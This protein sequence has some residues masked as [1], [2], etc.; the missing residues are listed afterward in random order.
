M[1]TPYITTGQTGPRK[2]WNPALTQREAL[3]VGF[4]KSE[5]DSATL[6]ARMTVDA[7]KELGT[8]RD[9][10]E[11]TLDVGDLLSAPYIGNG[12][13]ELAGR[14]ESEADPRIDESQGLVENVKE[15]LDKIMEDARPIAA[16]EFGATYSV[17]GAVDRVQDHNKTIEEDEGAGK[18]HHRRVPRLMRRLATWAPWI[19]AAGFFTFISYYLNV[20]LLEPWQDWFGW[21]FG[22]SVVVVIIIGQTILVRHAA[23]D[24]NHAREANANGNRHPAEASRIQ[25]NRY[26]ALTAVTAVAVTSGMIWRG[27]AALGDASFGVTA[28]M[29]FVAAVTGLLLP[30]LSYLGMALDGSRV[31]RERDSLVAQLDKDLEWHQATISNGRRDLA[32]AAAIADTLKGRTFLDICSTTQEAVDEVYEF[33]AKIRLLIGGLSADPP[34]RTTRTIHYDANN[35]ITGGYIG[36]SIPGAHTVNLGPLFD[37]ARHLSELERQAA[38]LMV[39]ID[40]AS[41]H[42]W[43]EPR[44]T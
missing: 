39:L 35:N 29:V 24:H 20:P 6:Y 2:H 43:G 38:A 30:T 40:A 10:W 26:L 32:D 44:T 5:Y 1:S 12:E 36:T 8:V 28:V 7:Y 37:R 15:G 14:L 4:S 17:P 16:P 42:P 27:V 18:H 3:K 9:R 13:Q 21:S 23:K 22:V 31:S 25:R 34:A 33:Y 19:E 11:P 41:T